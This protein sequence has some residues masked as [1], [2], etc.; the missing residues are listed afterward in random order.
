MCTKLM[1]A[2]PCLGAAARQCAV[3]FSPQE[4]DAARQE[5]IEQAVAAREG[6]EKELQEERGLRERML[7]LAAG[8]Q[9]PGQAAEAAAADAATSGGLGLQMALKPADCGASNCSLGGWISS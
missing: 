1:A 5:A 8:G 4:I 6:A 9:L 7:Q 3:P 2:V